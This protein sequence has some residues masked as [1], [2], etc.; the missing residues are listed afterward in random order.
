MKSIQKVMVR[1]HDKIVKLLTELG[2]CIDFDKKILKRAFESFNWELEKHIFTEEKIVF[3]SYEPED[4]EEGY[5]MVPQLMKEHDQIYNK[6]KEMRNS[7]I[8]GKFRD[9]Q[10]FKDLLLKHKN[11]EE[12]SLYPILDEEL[13]ETTKKLVIDRINEIKIFDDSLRNIKIKCS[14]CG[15]KMGILTGYHHSKLEKRWHLCSEC[16]D[17]I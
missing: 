4:Y 10:G 8:S 3:I 9:Y 2:K 13:D 11:F 14:E 5:K 17:K 6:L 7:I 16:Y 12:K 15:K 1:D